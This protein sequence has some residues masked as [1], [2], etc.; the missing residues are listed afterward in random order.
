MKDGRP[1]LQCDGKS[2]VDA[3]GHGDLGEGEEQGDAVEV[4]RQGGQSRK[5]QYLDS[6]A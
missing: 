2:E 4:S 5:L 6:P 3:A 1:A